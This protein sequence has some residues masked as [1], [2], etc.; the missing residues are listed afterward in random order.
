MTVGF[1]KGNFLRLDL[2]R[3]NNCRLLGLRR[4]HGGCFLLFRCHLGPHSFHGHRF[5]P[6]ILIGSLR[7]CCV[8]MIVVQFAVVVVEGAVVR[9][10]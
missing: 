2:D 8:L 6:L 10:P 4:G 7:W 5:Y 1:G 9:T 3:W